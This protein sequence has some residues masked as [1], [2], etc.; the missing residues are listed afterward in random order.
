M[1]KNSNIIAVTMGDPSG[2]GT[3]I[4]IKA[5]ETLRKDLLKQKKE[6]KLIYKSKTINPFFQQV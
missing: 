3:E 1:S 6:H 2:V 5:K 4:A